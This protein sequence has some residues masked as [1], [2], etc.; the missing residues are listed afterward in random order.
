MSEKKKSLLSSEQ[1]R[2][3]IKEGNIK[4]TRRYPSGRYK[5]TVLLYHPP[6]RKNDAALCRVVSHLWQGQ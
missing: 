2:Q 3:L 5:W 6:Q 4:N 1:I